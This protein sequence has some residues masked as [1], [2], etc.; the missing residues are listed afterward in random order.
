[1]ASLLFPTLLIYTRQQIEEQT[2]G[3]RESTCGLK[4]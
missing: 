3:M 4:Q 1:L 2:Y